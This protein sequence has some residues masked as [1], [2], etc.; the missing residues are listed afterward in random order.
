MNQKKCECGCGKIAPI[1]AY[2]HAALGYVKGKPKRFC[3]GH[4]KRN[5]KANPKFRHGVRINGRYTV[6]YTAWKNM[7]ERCTNPR[8][9]YYYCYGGIGITVCKRW[10]GKKGFANFLK[11]IGPKPKPYKRYSLG[12]IKI[13][14]GYRPS[15]CEWQTWETQ[16]NPR[17]KR[18]S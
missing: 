3:C 9:D 8:H 1:S 14:I 16:N 7:T 13:N 2:S 18:R 12:R 5:G 17:N 15:N 10:Q 4:Y 11:D 6:E